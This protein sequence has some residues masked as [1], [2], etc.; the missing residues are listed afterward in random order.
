MHISDNNK[1]TVT[2][3][4]S[5]FISDI[6][7]NCN[8]GIIAL[9]ICSGD[10]VRSGTKSNFDLAFD[11]FIEP[12]LRE[13]NLSESQFIY[14]PGNH[15]VDITKIDTDFSESFTRRILKNGVTLEDLK[16]P[17]VTAR[18]ATFFD[19]SALFFYWPSEKLAFS[20]NITISNVN[21]GITLVNS[22]WN[23]AGYSE[24]EAKKILI[25]SR[26]IAPCA[27]NN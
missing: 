7:S 25:S 22:A 3:L 21:Y 2:E 5:S 20:R 11:I 16:K 14:V 23:T 9:L 10:L 19:Y 4:C 1:E 26:R 6:K 13:L 18:L 17:N 15:E 27:Q 8:D 12:V 24:Y